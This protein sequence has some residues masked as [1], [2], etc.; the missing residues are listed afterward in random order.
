[1]EGDKDFPGVVELRAFGEVLGAVVVEGYDGEV[2]DRPVSDACSCLARF[3]DARDHQ[4]V[5]EFWV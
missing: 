4:V 1:M 3:V 2:S 5:S